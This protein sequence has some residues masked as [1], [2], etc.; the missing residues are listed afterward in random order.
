MLL[1]LLLPLLLA[2]SLSTPAFADEDEDNAAPGWKPT[3]TAW[4]PRDKVRAAFPKGATESGRA[5]L[6][7]VIAPDGKLVDCR[8]ARETPAGQ[9]FGQAALD[10]VKYERVKTK[11]E[12]GAS[13]VGRTARTWFSL[14]A[15]GDA[16]PN[17]VRRP[18]PGDLAAV[19]PV[20]AMEAG[21]GGRATIGCKV[22]VEG[23]LDAC[24]VRSEEP[25]GLNFGAAALQLAPQLRMTPRIR[26]GKPVAGGEVNIPIVWSGAPSV[27]NMGSSVILDPPWDRAPTQ[28][29][30]NA[31]WPKEAAGLPSGQAALRCELD[32]SG[33]LRA[34]QVISESP[35]NK[36]FGRAAK[37]LSKSF[38]VVLDPNDVKA[39]RK[40]VVDV[41]FRFRDPAAPDARKLTKPRWIR[42]LSAEGMAEVYPEAAVKAGVKAGQGAITC[43]VT[44]AGELS[45]CQAVREAPAGLDFGAAAIKA[46]TAMRMNPWTKEGDTVDG[47][48]ITLPITFTLEDDAPATPKAGGQ[49]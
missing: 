33:Q 28:A 45:A 23:F 7:C 44:A 36:G 24:K 42:G 11:D 34:C 3:W 43:T 40:Y 8:I 35:R 18:T 26:G 29:E 30:I 13:T 19:F 6:D 15:P 5:A 9:G 27:S 4:A 21:R 17:W 41:P 12:N 49:P 31:A 1:R 16:E 48:V 47:L 39:A 46:A 37:T 10:L 14:L 32:T 38:R 25:A 2:A 20:K 22:T